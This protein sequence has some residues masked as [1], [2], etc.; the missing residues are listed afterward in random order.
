[1]PGHRLDVW[2][3]WWRRKRKF[4]SPSREEKGRGCD[5][6]AI[7]F[8]GSGAVDVALPPLQLWCVLGLAL[9]ANE[10]VK[11]VE[12]TKVAARRLRGA[13]EHALLLGQLLGQADQ[14]L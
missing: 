1:M 2:R 11:A 14:A 6:P 12:A 7:A 9:V 3:G 8:G 5:L 13:A 10:R 4:G